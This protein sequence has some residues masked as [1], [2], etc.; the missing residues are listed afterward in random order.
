MI[1]WRFLPLAHAT[2]IIDID[3]RCKRKHLP[4]AFKPR[5]HQA[6]Q[7]VPAEQSP[8]TRPEGLLPLQ[9]WSW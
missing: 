6:C 8:G 9:R 4:C 3:Y 5:S 1:L 2:A 7:A